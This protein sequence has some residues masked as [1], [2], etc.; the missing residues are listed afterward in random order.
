MIGLRELVEALTKEKP[1][2]E[3]VPAFRFSG[4]VIDSRLAR[5]GFLF[6][7]LKG[8]NTDGHFFVK[9][10]F[11]RGAVAALVERE[12]EF[13]CS[14]LD[15]RTRPVQWLERKVEF[16]VCLL[17]SETLRA[18]QEAAAFWRRRNVIR[19]VGV[20]GSIGKTTTKELIASVL[21]RRFRTLKSYGNYNNEIGL[22]LTLLHLGPEHERAVLE[23]GMHALGDIALLAD[24]ALPAV[25]VVTCVEPVHLERLGT[26]ERIAQAKAE[27]V[28]ALP[29]DGVAV[30]NYDDERVRAMKDKTKARVFYYGLDPRADLWADEIQSEGLAGVRFRFRYGKEILHARIPLLGRHSVHTALAAA[31]VGLVEGLS[32]GE[33]MAGLKDTSAQVRLMA[34]RGIRD[35]TILDDTYNASPPSTLAALSV[36]GELAGRRIAV[37]GDMLELG[38]YEEEGHR[39]VGRK[40]V[41]VASILITVGPRARMIAQEALACGM[42]PEKVHSFDSREEAVALLL[43]L[44]EP[45]DVVLVKGSRGMRMEEIV[46]AIMAR[47]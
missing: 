39:K 2:E 23:M 17:V 24:I 19:V 15:L 32:W 7:A 21:S 25:G 34:V 18:L 9:E 46:K 42:P 28:E 11:D 35:S 20:T 37:L 22:P 14:L 45:G 12:P 40:A 41:E 13:P 26:I 38:S 8:E 4:V 44:L 16:P 30:L 47:D 36:L 10:A 33:I 6:I 5:E 27:L 1:P 29:P 43:E 3:T 31:A